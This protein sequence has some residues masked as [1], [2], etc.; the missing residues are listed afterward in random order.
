MARNKNIPYF[1]KL[2]SNAH[3]Y[4]RDCAAPTLLCYC[5]ADRSAT[6]PERTAPIACPDVSPRYDL[7]FLR[8][9][10]VA[11][12]GVFKNGLILRMLQTRRNIFELLCYRCQGRARG[13]ERSLVLECVNLTCALYFLWGAGVA[14]GR[15]F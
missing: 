6:R 1:S 5:Y 2:L 13:G 9:L 12:A 10:R 15:R 3:S 11:D 8:K 4:G 7:G 14:S